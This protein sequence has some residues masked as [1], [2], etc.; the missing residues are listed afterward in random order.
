MRKLSRN[1]VIMLIMPLFSGLCL[2][3]GDQGGDGDDDNTN[4]N[5]KSILRFSGMTA[6]GGERKS[7]RDCAVVDM[8]PEIYK[9]EVSSGF[10]QRGALDDLE[11]HII[12]E[13]TEEMILLSEMNVEVELPVGKYDNFKI[14]MGEGW[15]IYLDC[16]GEEFE[17]VMG[18]DGDNDDS[19]KISIN[20]NRGAWGYDEQGR[21][22][23]QAAGE[24]LGGFEIRPGIITN[25]VFRNNLKRIIWDDAD[26]SGDWSDGDSFEFI[27]EEGVITMSDMIVTYEK[28]GEI[29]PDEE[30]PVDDVFEDPSTG[31]IWEN[32]P[33]VLAMSFD[34]AEEYCEQLTLG[35]YSDWRVPD[36]EELRSLL[37][38]CDATVT[39]GTC[40][41]GV[42]G[43]NDIDSCSDSSCEGC[44]AWEGPGDGCYRIE[45]LAGVCFNYWS[46]TP[47]TVSWAEEG[48]EYVGCISFM[49]AEIHGV[50]VTDR[51]SFVRCVR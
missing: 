37:V 39:G 23:N 35:E 22:I 19:P 8:G 26:E 20:N 1:M 48:E 24:V 30:D 33:Q 2:G 17:L 9:I 13:T 38:G 11:W 6:G 49:V 51:S 10:V 18:R 34:E 42:E 43:C 16:N 7:T 45:N 14:T 21:F 44:W 41:L 31:L 27:L 29:L 5:A 4:E 28:D 15:N 47:I 32:N 36:I 12:F 46:S 40:G 3:C 50:L 25:A